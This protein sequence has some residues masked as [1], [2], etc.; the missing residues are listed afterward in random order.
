MGWYLYQLKWI[1]IIT[2]IRT[3][4]SFMKQFVNENCVYE[5]GPVIANTVLGDNSKM[6]WSQVGQN[7]DACEIQ[8][9]SFMFCPIQP[10]LTLLFYVRFCWST[11]QSLQIIMRNRMRDRSLFYC[12]F[13]KSYKPILKIRY[14]SL[15]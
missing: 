13:V 10:D 6:T 5:S 4:T 3:V 9:V 8:G 2:S 15:K 12:Y 11:Y 7:Y 14:F 1:Q